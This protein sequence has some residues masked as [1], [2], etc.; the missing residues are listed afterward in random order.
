V[1][2]VE[3]GPPPTYVHDPDMI[4]G[5]R[6]RCLDS[7]LLGVDS[8]T[9][10]KKYTS[11]TDQVVCFSLSP[12]E[13]ARYFVPRKFL[14]AFKD[15]LEEETVPKAVSNILFDAHRFANGGVEIK[16][17]WV[18]TP[19]L[20]FLLD[21]DTRENH[22]GLKDCM[23]DYFGLPMAEY[24]DLF[25]KDDTTQ[26]SPAHP[27]W[28]QWVD[29]ASLDAWA[30]RKLAIHLMAQLS[31]VHLDHQGSA[32]LMDLYWATEEPQYK[33]LH[34][35]ERRG[36]SIDRELIHSISDVM[37]RRGEELARELNRRVGWSFNPAS[38]DHVARYL[39]ED[40]GLEVISL[41]D[42]GKPQTTEA[43]L[44]Q[45]IEIDG[46][47]EC[48]MI[49]DCREANKA[50][51]QYCDGIIKRL[52]TDGRLHTSFNAKLLTGRLSSSDP[53]LQNIPTGD[54]GGKSFR[55]AFWSEEGNVLIVA[56]Y[57]QLEMR[58]L[59]EA[60]SELTMIEGIKSGLD[61]HVFTASMMFNV[62]YEE[63]FQKA[64]VEEVK[65]YK[66]MRGAAKA[67]G[68]GIIYGKTA[69]GL[70][71]DLKITLEEAQDFLDKYLNTYP[72]VRNFIEGQIWHAQKFGY[73]QTL[74]GRFRRLSLINSSDKKIRKHA[75]NQAVNSVIQGSA[76][77]LVKHGMISTNFDA[78]LVDELNCR[79]IL[80]IHDELVYECPKETAE[81]ACRHIQETLENPYVYPLSV[82]LKSKPKVVRRW[83]EAK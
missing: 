52:W 60:A 66:R 30:H 5:V 54:Y 70:S 2:F 82:P 47:E 83:G 77:D 13:D 21:E 68:F 75:E 33:T 25:G 67:I 65:E 57:S 19:H 55:D 43:V 61:M 50:K 24:K 46:I 6:R 31:N 51:S 22:H 80:Q 26:Y 27:K 72:N 11:M 40:L 41:T 23:K 76:A 35:M 78:Y 79:L 62:P 17:K 69:Y 36:I 18:D 4:D 64:V 58:L 14:P 63:M 7:S 49:L 74:S 38:A 9:L 56:D 73:V 10:G 71:R 34:Q 45:H 12:D 20:D 29:Y 16:G 8:E 3:A 15:V 1:R 81:L 39:Y 48:Q 42:G 59:A 44:K 53:N 28:N 32:T 37:E